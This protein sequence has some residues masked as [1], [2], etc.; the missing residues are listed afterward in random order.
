MTKKGKKNNHSH[1]ISNSE[2]KLRFAIRKS[3][4]IHFGQHV[5]RNLKFK[6]AELKSIFKQ[7][8]VVDASEINKS[9]GVDQTGEYINTLLGK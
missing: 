5:H 3:F 8:L 4:S 2:T 9:D 1:Q 7:S 6:R